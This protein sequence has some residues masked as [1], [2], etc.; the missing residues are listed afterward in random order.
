[1]FRLK[2]NKQTRVYA[3]LD[4]AEK[5]K[6]RLTKIGYY[7]EATLVN[8]PVAKFQITAI[9]PERLSLGELFYG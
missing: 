4:L 1:M 2:L 5:L 6:R 7:V 8:D 3:R 9:K